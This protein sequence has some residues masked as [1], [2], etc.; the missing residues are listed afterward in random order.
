MCIRDRQRSVENW[1]SLCLE[2]SEEES[3]DIN[4]DRLLRFVRH[5]VKYFVSTRL[6]ILLAEERVNEDEESF[7]LDGIQRWDLTSRLLRN[8]LDERPVNQGLLQAQGLLP[9]GALAATS[10]AEAEREA[11]PIIEKLVDYP[12]CKRHPLLVDMEFENGFRISGQIQDYYPGKGL[13]HYSASRLKGKLLLPLWLEHLVLCASNRFPEGEH[14][15]LV[16]KDEGRQFGYIPCVRAHQLLQPYLGYYLDGL[17]R[18]LPVLP[19]ASYAWASAANTQQARKK[20][21]E[22]WVSG[23][24]YRNSGTDSDDP[25]I[26][27]VL[28]GL[29]ANP[30]EHPEFASLA[31]AFFKE[32]LQ[33]GKPL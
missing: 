27:L 17:R 14:S 2:P 24:S 23:N 16:C 26:Q 33:Q 30:V 9:H 32:A 18:P 28:R 6:R 21:G 22:K 25:Y 20:A 3:K 8:F 31:D 11:S 10:F 13:L 15:T 7:A 5:P 4:L 12:G 29:D 19:Q 1:P